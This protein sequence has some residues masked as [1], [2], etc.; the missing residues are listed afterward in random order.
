MWRAVFT[1]QRL[2]ARALGSERAHWVL[3]KVVT[4]HSRPTPSQLHPNSAL[5]QHAVVKA[6]PARAAQGP[7]GRGDARA[8]PGRPEVTLACPLARRHRAR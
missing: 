5:C 1:Q 2:R 3:K 4:G 7:R 8:G 6:P